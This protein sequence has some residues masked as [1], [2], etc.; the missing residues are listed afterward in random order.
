[1]FMLLMS[2]GK[3]MSW[4]SKLHNDGTAIDDWFI[5]GVELP[6]GTITYHLPNDYWN[7]LNKIPCITKLDRAPEW[8]GHTSSDVIGRIAMTILDIE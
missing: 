2:T 1:L 6:I 3:Y 5:A 7:Y 4:V 8:D